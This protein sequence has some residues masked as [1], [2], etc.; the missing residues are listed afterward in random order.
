MREIIYSEAQEPDMENK[1]EKIITGAEEARRQFRDFWKKNNSPKALKKELEQNEKDRIE[2][3]IRQ[4]DEMTAWLYYGP[5]DEEENPEKKEFNF[6]KILIASGSK[7]K[8]DILS[9]IAEKCGLEIESDTEDRKKRE[10]YQQTFLKRFIKNDAKQKNGGRLESY[11]LDVAQLKAA[12]VYNNREN[13]PIIASD[14]VVLEGLNILEK[15]KSKEDAIKILSDLSGKEVNI[16]CGVAL[17]TQTKSGKEI[18][19][20]EG[21]NFVIKLR[22]FSIQEAENYIDRCGGDVLNVA[23]VID[24]SNANAKNLIDSNIAIKVE[25]LKLENNS[26]EQ[27]LISPEILSG[28]KDYFKGAPEE[29]IEEMLDRQK[30]LSEV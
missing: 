10:I 22:D 27:I 29:L 20:N 19:L 21:I 26:N 25:P 30:A 15:P 6:N 11:A 4:G 1:E 3:L 14:I 5:D 28:L 18:M 17:L 23:G 16:S 2:E 9:G 13:N 24:Y 7:D 8:Q 12:D